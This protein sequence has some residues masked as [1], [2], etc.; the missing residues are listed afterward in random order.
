M[1]PTGTAKAHLEA[2]E[3]AADIIFHR[4]VYDIISAVEEFRHP[5]LLFQIVFHGFVAT[6]RGLEFGDPPRVEDPAA[7]E[8]KTAAVAA[9]VVGQPF[10]VR[11]AVDVNDQRCMLIRLYRLEP[12]NDLVLHH[13][14]QQPL[15]LRQHDS[16]LIVT[17]EPFEIAQCQRD[18]DQE[19]R[20]PLEQTAKPICTKDL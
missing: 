1:L 19:V 12:A 20:L 6:R 17:K 3:P 18:A 11:K 15:E 14:M 9:L 10:F 4:D 13:E 7:V 8:D 5:R 16:Y 2:R